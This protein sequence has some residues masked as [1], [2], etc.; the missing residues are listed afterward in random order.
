MPRPSSCKSK[1]RE[2]IKLTFTLLYFKAPCLYNPETVIGG[3]R[4][5]LQGMSR[6]TVALSERT[7][8][9]VKD[10]KRRLASKLGRKPSAEEAI[11][12]ALKGYRSLSDVLGI[13]ETLAGDRAAAFTLKTG[14]VKSAAY[15]YVTGLELSPAESA[16]RSGELKGKLENVN[17]TLIVAGHREVGEAVA[18]V[19]LLFIVKGSGSTVEEAMEVADAKATALE[20]ALRYAGFKAERVT[21]SGHVART[22]N[23]AW[24]VALSFMEPGDLEKPVIGTEDELKPLVEALRQF[25]ASNPVFRTQLLTDDP[26]LMLT[27]AQ[28]SP[29]AEVEGTVIKFR[30]AKPIDF[31]RRV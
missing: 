8:E 19:E 6:K 12:Q 22:L 13:E 11:A 31:K 17:A 28:V 25:I 7:W 16:R 5:R 4:R 15:I 14:E 23:K 26:A 9:A 21:G 2:L 20:L 24:R 29:Y 1:G 30:D 10:L 18:A 27:I 3:R